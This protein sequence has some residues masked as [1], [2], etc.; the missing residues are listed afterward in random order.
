M[1]TQILEDIGM[2]NAEIKVY[3]ALLELGSTTAGPVIDKSGLQNSVVHMTLHKLI[4]KGFASYVREGKIKHYQAIDPKNILR[5]IDEKKERFQELLPELLI[6][7][8]T[9]KEKQEIT[10]FRGK[11]GVKELMYALL[12]AGGKEHVTIG[13]PAESLMLPDEWWYSYHKKRA[14][15]GIKARLLFYESLRYWKAEKKYKNAEVRYTA[16][17]KEPLTETIIRNDKVGIIIWTEKPMGILFHHKKMA[18]S[19]REF[20]ELTWKAAKK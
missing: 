14:A 20:F 11:N 19:Y 7:Q 10:V 12:E 17:G 8:Q 9:A 13:A 1:D 3:L 16:V 15:K 18:D 6:K 4:E 5:Y 2:T